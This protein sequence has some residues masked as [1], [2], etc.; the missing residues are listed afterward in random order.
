MI[1]DRP[2]A[3]VKADN[4]TI[5]NNHFLKKIENQKQLRANIIYDNDRNEIPEWM[6]QATSKL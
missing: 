4:D 6:R 5:R 2:L 3:F 1:L